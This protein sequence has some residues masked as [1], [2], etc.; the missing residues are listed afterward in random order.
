VLEVVKILRVAHLSG[1][2][3]EFPSGDW[4]ADRLKIGWWLM[5]LM[6]V[7]DIVFAGGDRYLRRGRSFSW[8]WRLVRALQKWREPMVWTR[9]RCL[10]GDVHSI[11]ANWSS[12]AQLWF[13]SRSQ[14]RM[15]LPARRKKLR[16]R[17][18]AP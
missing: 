4:G 8:R 10:S 9:T 18:Y 5:Q 11:G 6:R 2:R 7:Q 3:P 15:R 12:H 16:R 13:R 1:K 17:P 14:E